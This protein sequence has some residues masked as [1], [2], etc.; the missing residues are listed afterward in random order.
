MALA[1]L[2]ARG[3]D[4]CRAFVEAHF[5]VTSGCTV[6]SCT[7]ERLG[8]RNARRDNTRRFAMETALIPSSLVINAYLAYTLSA[9]LH[10]SLSGS[11][12]QQYE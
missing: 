2:S 7:W 4:H 9:E 5:A 10:V 3:V 1:R 6:E 11:Q 8:R 12:L